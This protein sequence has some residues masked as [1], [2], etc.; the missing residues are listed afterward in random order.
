M[1]AAFSQFLR[2]L[3]VGF[4]NTAVGF[5]VFLVLRYG[6][7][8]PLNLS[9]GIGYAV[10]LIVAYY[11][12]K[13]FVFNDQPSQPGKMSLFVICFLLA[14]GLNLVVLNTSAYVF[15]LP[16]FAAQ[17]FAMGAYTIVFFALNK[18]VV[19]RSR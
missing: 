17:L 9:N 15:H 7:K 4:L 12:N 3:V 14:F 10:A 8:I 11:L 1:H 6:M 13:H 19:F 16:D 2:F 18:Y 5:S